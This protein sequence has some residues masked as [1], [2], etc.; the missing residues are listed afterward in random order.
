MKSD[1]LSNKKRTLVTFEIAFEERELTLFK[2]GRTS[3]K[4]NKISGLTIG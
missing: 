3:F 2:L 4:A 1:E